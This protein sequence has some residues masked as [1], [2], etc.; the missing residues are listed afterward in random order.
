M[1]IEEMRK[2]NGAVYRAKR[3]LQLAIKV[4]ETTSKYDRLI[5]EYLNR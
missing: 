4:F 5:S 3:I 2:N 1:V